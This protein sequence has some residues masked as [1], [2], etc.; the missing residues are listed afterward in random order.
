MMAR[1]GSSRA[2]ARPRHA[3][4]AHPS[5][6]EQNREKLAQ[7]LRAAFIHFSNRDLTFKRALNRVRREGADGWSGVADAPRSFPRSN[8]TCQATGSL[9]NQ[10]SWT[11]RADALA[12]PGGRSGRS[13]VFA[14]AR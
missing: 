14:E 7:Y 1:M 13:I 10:S 9:Q 3:R 11:L 2:G 12:L 8:S 6:R 4:R 5:S